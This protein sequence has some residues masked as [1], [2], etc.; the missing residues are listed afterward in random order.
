[1]LGSVQTG[2]GSVPT[3]GEPSG[4]GSSGNPWTTNTLV[5]PATSLTSTL[6]MPVDGTDME[7]EA[8]I[9]I[10]NT[11]QTLT[12][13]LSGDTESAQ[14]TEQITTV[15]SFPAND[16]IQITG[17]DGTTNE[18]F[19]YF[20]VVQIAGNTRYLTMQVFTRIPPDASSSVG[21]A[22]TAF[23]GSTARVSSVAISS[24]VANGLGTGT[25]LRGRS[26]P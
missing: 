24:S 4:G 22:S 8:V 15:G 10:N 20:R 7:F 12:I 23:L 2:L 16:E 18:V 26:L 17:I 14:E 6:A 5:A 9:Q 11:E 13:I 1:M 21:L 19:V 25:V 3:A